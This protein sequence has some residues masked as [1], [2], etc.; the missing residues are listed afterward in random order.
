MDVGAPVVEGAPK[1]EELPVPDK[2]DEPLEV[3]RVPNV[4]LPSEV[5]EGPVIERSSEL[6]GLSEPDKVNEESEV[7]GP[8]VV[9]EIE[10]DSEF[11]GEE[12]EEP[13]DSVR[14]LVVEEP[15]LAPEEPLEAK[16]DDS[17]EPGAIVIVVLPSVIAVADTGRET[18]SLPTIMPPGPMVSV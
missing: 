1:F 10:T 5:V 4:W 3:G 15:P 18:V 8:D 17:G 11:V 9:R 7:R 13:S 12:P 6:D 16:A 2:V 14:L